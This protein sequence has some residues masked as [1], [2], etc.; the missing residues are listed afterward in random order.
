M[1]QVLFSF[2]K[3]HATLLLLVGGVAGYVLISGTTGS[4]PA[5]VAI[6]QAVGI[7]SLVSSAEA[8]PAGEARKAP[9]WKLTDLDGKAVSSADFEGKVI[10]L[11][12]WATWCPPCRMM[13][14]GM[15]EL[16]ETYREKG[17]VIIG[18]SLDEQGPEVVRKFNKE[19]N[20]NYTSLMG[21]EKVVE[22]FGGIRGIPTSFLIDRDGNI[23]RKHVGYLPKEKLET[24]IKPLL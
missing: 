11:D 16:Q 21:T 8:A 14:P 19:F 24:D 2:M 15:V 10:L 9:A 5:C 12:F 3:R 13:I 1:K 22:D 7:P 23:V 17:L 4:C 20:V 6:T 18:V